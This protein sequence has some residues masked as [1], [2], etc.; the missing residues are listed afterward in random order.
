MTNSTFQYTLL[1]MLSK[2]SND[3]ISSTSAFQTLQKLFAVFNRSY[4]FSFKTSE[5]KGAIL[6]A[7]QT[8]KLVANTKELEEKSRGVIKK[9][10]K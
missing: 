6:S 9:D 7:F 5:K 4:T 8:A 3:E 2:I 10:R 1:M